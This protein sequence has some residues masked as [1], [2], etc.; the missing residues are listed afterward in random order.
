MSKCHIFVTKE[1]NH[2]IIIC[3]LFLSNS[4]HRL[5]FFKIKIILYIEE[6]KHNSINLS[7]IL[8]TSLM[9]WGWTAKIVHFLIM[10]VSPYLP[11][12]VLE[13]CLL[14]VGYCQYIRVFLLK[15]KEIIN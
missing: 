4:P 9:M 1:F 5:I 8:L 12:H 15:I 2:H 14:F 3:L 7:I 13:W 10:L 11:L 6:S